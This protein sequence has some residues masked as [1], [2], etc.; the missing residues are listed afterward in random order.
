MQVFDQ[1][2]PTPNGKKVSVTHTGEMSGEIFAICE[3]K[4]WTAEYVSH[5]PP[6][7]LKRAL[8]QEMLRVE[9]KARKVAQTGKTRKIARLHPVFNSPNVM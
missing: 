7:F 2:L 9:E 3:V 5:L 6:D 1:H 8:W 4:Y